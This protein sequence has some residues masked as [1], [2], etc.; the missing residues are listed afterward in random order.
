MS[1]AHHDHSQWVEMNNQSINRQWAKSKAKK[2]PPTLPERLNVYQMRAVEILG[3][4]FGGIYNAPLHWE[5]ADWLE[6]YTTGG[7][8]IPT[9]HEIT[10]ATTDN[11]QLTFFVMFCHMAR[12]RGSIGTIGGRYQRLQFMMHGRGEDGGYSRRHPSLEEAVQAAN[13]YAWDHH[14]MRYRSRVAVSLELGGG[15]NAFIT[16]DQAGAAS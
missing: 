3:N 6:G 12:M 2:K 7:L 8:I 10:L 16:P 5:K 13:A 4:T 14:R 9:T 11:S 15:H 1:Y